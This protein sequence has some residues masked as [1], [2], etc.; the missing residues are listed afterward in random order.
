MQSMRVSWRLSIRSL[1][2]GQL[3]RGWAVGSVAVHVAAVIG[4][5]VLALLAAGCG[6][7]SS[8]GVANVGSGAS[9]TTAAAAS[10][11]SSSGSAQSANS[12]QLE[13]YSECM[14]SHGVPSFPDPVNGHLN[15]TVTKGGPLDPNSPQ[16]QSAAQACKSLAP[17]GL[18]GG[19]APSTSSQS[20]MLKF[21]QCMRSHGVKSFPDPTGNG[22]FLISGNI[23]NS[24]DFRSAMQACRPLLPGGTGATP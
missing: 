22:G 23:Q 8:N 21:A 20:Q 24:P 17:S 16:F 9:T 13:K 4:L 19:S 1:H 12:A 11:V 3:P 5:G 10:S 14:R 18:V 7:G 15:L 6:G 2:R